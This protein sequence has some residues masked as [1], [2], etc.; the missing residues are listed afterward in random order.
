MST[1]NS[2]DESSN[3][4]TS[5]LKIGSHISRKEVTKEAPSYIC[6]QCNKPNQM[7]ITFRD[8][9]C[10]HCGYRILYKARQRRLQE[11]DCT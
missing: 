3:G 10:K 11:Y 1:S 7:L 5:S 6:G 4:T 8:I 9:K 2:N